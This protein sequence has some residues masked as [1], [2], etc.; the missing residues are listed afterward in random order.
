MQASTERALCSMDSELLTPLLKLCCAAVQC[1][2][3]VL[4]M[5]N[6]LDTLFT[7]T[8]VWG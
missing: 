5:P 4:A 8:Q 6:T 2:P 3:D 7:M 1:V